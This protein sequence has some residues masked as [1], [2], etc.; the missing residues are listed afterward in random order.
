[1]TATSAHEGISA[2][3]ED[4]LPPRTAEAINVSITHDAISVRFAQLPQHERRG[5]G[6]G[7]RCS[8][9]GV[10]PRFQER[11]ARHAAQGENKG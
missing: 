5:G 9:P 4:D 2:C 8:S 10:V 3:G 6:S 7:G 1:M 11:P